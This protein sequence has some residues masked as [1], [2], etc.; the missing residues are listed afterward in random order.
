MKLIK[1]EQLPK[2]SLVELAKMYSRNWQTLDGLWF[3]NIEAEFG[4]EA[5][6][7]IDLQNWEKQSLLEAKRIKKVMQLDSGGLSSVLT[8]LSLMSWQLTSPVFEIEEETS[9]R[10]VFYYSQCAVQENRSK[11]MKAV[12]PC[13]P[14]KLKLLSN[15]AAVVEPRAVVNCITAPP[16]K[17]GA[18][19][20]CKWEFTLKQD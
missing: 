2:K 17:T 12:F 18:G 1:L 8:V 7:R 14:M 16:D 11:H 10:V 15:I 20:W 5:A 13:K 9:D 4:L 19:S 3:A 6:C